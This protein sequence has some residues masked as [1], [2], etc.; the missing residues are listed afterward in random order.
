MHPDVDV[1]EVDVDDAT[2]SSG[3]AIPGAHIVETSYNFTWTGGASI[4]TILGR[5]AFFDQSTTHSLCVA[6]IQ[7]EFPQNV[8]SRY[9]ANSPGNCE[10]VFGGACVRALHEAI[11]MPA[12]ANTCP[13][14][15]LSSTDG[16][17]GVFD[18]TTGIATFNG[19]A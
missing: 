15:P 18:I 5:N 7:A 4:S 2:D 1:T 6:V 11:T 8:V 9:D 17:E 16:C 13:D 19:R 12:N 3:Q 14:I 10:S